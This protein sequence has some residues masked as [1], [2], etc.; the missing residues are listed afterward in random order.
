MRIFSMAYSAIAAYTGDRWQWL[1]ALAYGWLGLVGGCL[2][3]SS[4]CAPHVSMSFVVFLHQ[5]SLCWGEIPWA[6][7]RITFGHSGATHNTKA[8]QSYEDERHTKLPSETPHQL[9]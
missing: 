1:V 6:R 4:G 7:P 3:R 2:S 8:M 9:F 5:T